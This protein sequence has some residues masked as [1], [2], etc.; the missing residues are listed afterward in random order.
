MSGI[1]IKEGSVMSEI[2]V[3]DIVQ[4]TTW[5]KLSDGLRKL[6]HTGKVL[7]FVPAGK[8][9]RNVWTEN[10]II[11]KRDKSGPNVSKNERAVVLVMGGAKGTLEYHCAPSIGKLKVVA[12][13][14]FE[15]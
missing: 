14:G 9:I 1:C 4:W 8:D 3:G 5:A 15:E 10:N 6:V 12:P 13:D 2:K 7:A 11:I